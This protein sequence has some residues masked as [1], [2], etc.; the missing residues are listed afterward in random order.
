MNISV[1]LTA[2]S[3]KAGLTLLAFP[4]A[5]LWKK[6]HVLLTYRSYVIGTDSLEGK[7]KKSQLHHMDHQN[8]S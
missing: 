3:H 8:Q 4:Q 1:V 2:C 6:K 7:E 5:A